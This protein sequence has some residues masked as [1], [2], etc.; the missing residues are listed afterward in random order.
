[1]FAQAR[2]TDSR[3][4]QKKTSYR[5]HSGPTGLFLCI[6]LQLHGIS[7]GCEKLILWRLHK[8]T[9]W[10]WISWATFK[11]DQGRITGKT[12]KKMLIPE[13]GQSSSEDSAGSALRHSQ[14]GTKLK[15]DWFPREKRWL[16]KQ[17]NSVW[18]GRTQ[19]LCVCLSVTER[20][21]ESS[22]LLGEPEAQR[23]VPALHDS[24]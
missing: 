16:A 4:L 10:S 1:M 3:L 14:E 20:E 17:V 9:R 18:H 12:A 6:W 23:R 8:I 22:G 13:R 5:N 7:Y 2:F 15:T 11:S 24:T 21:R 19:T